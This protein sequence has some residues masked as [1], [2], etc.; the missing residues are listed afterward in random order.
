MLPDKIQKALPTPF[1]GRWA[2]GIMIMA[3]QAGE[4]DYS[5]NKIKLFPAYHMRVPI[6]GHYFDASAGLDLTVMQVAFDV[7]KSIVGYTPDRQPIYASGIDEPAHIVPDF[8]G[9]V[10]LGTKFKEK[11]PFNIGLAYHHFYTSTPSVYK[12]NLSEIMPRRFSAT[13]NTIIP[14]DTN[15]SKQLIPSAIFTYQNPG[16]EGNVGSLFWLNT[17]SFSQLVPGLYVGAF[18]RLT[19]SPDEVTSVATNVQLSDIIA[20]AG[21]DFALFKKGEKITAASTKSRVGDFRV[22]FA[23]DITTSLYNDM[24]SKGYNNS[25]ELSIQYTFCNKSFDY[26]PPFKLNPVFN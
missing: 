9:G 25:L 10:N 15:N 12:D 8:S 17:R 24:V 26:T 16:W 22:L 21:F 7:T 23:Y 6:F 1:G 2:A 19:N 4:V 3:D 11:Y 13:S 14:L 18:C 20:A 5:Y